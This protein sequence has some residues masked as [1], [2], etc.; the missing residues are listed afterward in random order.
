M[1]FKLEK[2][3]SLQTEIDTI[4]GSISEFQDKID[5]MNDTIDD[6]QTKQRKLLTNALVSEVK[7]I[8]KKYPTLESFVSDV[9]GWSFLGMFGEE[10]HSV[11]GVPIAEIGKDIIEIMNMYKATSDDEGDTTLEVLSLRVKILPD[12]TFVVLPA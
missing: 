10:I 8:L 9:F 4:R 2:V 11:D 7:R 5:R 3:S 6:L 12:G 1:K